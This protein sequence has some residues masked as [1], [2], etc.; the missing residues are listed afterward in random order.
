M[1]K[2]EGMHFYINILN[3]DNV[4][5]DEERRTNEVNHSIHALDT[6]FSM[7]ENFGKRHFTQNFF[8]EKITG[9][10][11]HMYVSGMI[12]DSFEIVAE[13]TAF[14]YKL[15]SFLNNEISKYKT[16][17]DFQIQVGACYGKFYEFKFIKDGF[18]EDTTI[19]YA[20]NYAA[21][22]QGISSKSYI[23]IASNIYENLDAE[24]Q[25]IFLVKEDV[26]IKKYKQTY[27]AT[28]HI[29]SLN[30]SIDFSKDLE[31]AKKYANTLNLSN[32]SF[33]GVRQ[34]LDFDYLSKK[35]C[36]RLVGIPFFADVR[37]FTIQFE[38]DDS[39]LEEMA[40]K[41]Q[42]IL[43][44]MY[45]I[46]KS[47]KGIHVQFQGD[48]E[49]ALFHD[50][51]DYHCIS[52]ALVAALRIVDR[53][54]EFQVSIGVGT[55]LG[56]VFASKIGARGEKDNILLGSTVTQADRYEDEKA[57][58]NQIVIN[59]RIYLELKKD[60]TVWA[61][62]FTKIGPDCYRTTVGYQ[63]MMEAVSRAQLT[64]NTRSNNYN[65]AWGESIGI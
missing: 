32:I 52:D 42:N 10:R 38:K 27:Y 64:E 54:K 28:T 53:V 41:T 39:N 22:L 65:G 9:S 2:N 43:E 6:Y 40:V 16:L 50:Y 3:M 14:A 55:C 33:G 44:S 35:E 26:S 8:V 1:V 46:V 31:D 36:K 57:G 48:R 45:T 11:L 34:E 58:E 15:T 60:R 20:A 23:S 63:K 47:N 62:Q 18:E 4:V 13:V 51:G 24:Y 12:T 17:L 49:M 29:S 25:N 21:K 19:G 56:T 5:A 59:E 61:E 30:T 7:I 37:E